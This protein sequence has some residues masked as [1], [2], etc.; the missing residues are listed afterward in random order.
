[1]SDDARLNARVVDRMRNGMMIVSSQGHEHP[2]P[3][4]DSGVIEP[5]FSR[6]GSLRRVWLGSLVIACV[7]GA[8]TGCTPN[9]STSQKAEDVSLS[10]QAS[11][12][13]EPARGSLRFGDAMHPISVFVAHDPMF[14]LKVQCRRYRDQ[15]IKA[16]VADALLCY[17]EKPRKAF[18]RIRVEHHP[19]QTMALAMQRLRS[20]AE[21][22][23]LVVERTGSLYQL[24][25]LGFAPW[26]DGSYRG[27]EIRVLSGNEQG[28]QALLAALRKR[29][30]PL[31]VEVLRV[32]P[33]ELKSQSH[34]PGVSRP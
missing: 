14:D 27:D 3:C 29:W 13:T 2:R 7:L 1:M 30:S 17:D 12:P 26:R 10:T 22:A 4:C 24:L 23:H 32:D 28:H 20:G 25:D 31:E 6:A 16:G 9:S 18:S 19:K 33:S 11:E 15:Q 5:S 34:Q 8:L 21:A